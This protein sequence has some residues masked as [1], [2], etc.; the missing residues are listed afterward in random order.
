MTTFQRK[1]INVPDRTEE[2][3]DEHF[4]HDPEFGARWYVGPSEPP[5]EEEIKAYEASLEETK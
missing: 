1:A 3:K 4:Q 2:P 5:T